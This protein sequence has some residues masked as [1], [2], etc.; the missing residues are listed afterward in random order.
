MLAE[1]DTWRSAP[2]VVA[3]EAA[4]DDGAGPDGP[5]LRFAFAPEGWV[6]EVGLIGTLL[7]A[8]VTTADSKTREKVFRNFSREVSLGFENRHW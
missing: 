7:H 2:P 3:A 6:T 5:L 1:S 8:T 4:N